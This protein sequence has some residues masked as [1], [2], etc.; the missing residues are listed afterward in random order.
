VAIV[1]AIVASGDKSPEKIKDELIIF[2]EKYFKNYS[3]LGFIIT[4][5]FRIA[6]KKIG[7]PGY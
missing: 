7:N 2:A 3:S 5:L 4:E 1:S 6:D